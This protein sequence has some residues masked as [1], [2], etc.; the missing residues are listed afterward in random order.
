MKKLKLFLSLITLSLTVILVLASI[1]SASS[2]PFKDV[3]EKN[4]FYSYVEHVYTEGIMEGKSETIFDPN[5]N[6]TRAEFVT[7]IARLAEANTEGCRDSLE[8][9]TDA[10]KN[11]WYADAMGWGVKEGLVTGTSENTLAPNEAMTRAQLATFVAR[12]NDYLGITLPEDP[13][14]VRSFT[15]VKNGKWYSD[16]VEA[17][18]ESGLINGNGDGK[19]RPNDTSKRSETAAIISRFLNAVPEDTENDRLEEIAVIHINTETGTDVTSKEDY[20]RASFTLKDKE[21]RDIEVSSMRIRGRG[22]ATWNMEK[23]S[24]RLKFDEKI[25]LMSN[26]SG[27]TTENKDWTLLANHCDKSHLRNIIAMTLGKNLE[28][29]DWSPYTELV[30][31]YLNGEYRGIYMLS[32]QV[33]VGDQRVEIEDGEKDDIGFLIEL[34]NYAAGEFLSD[35][36][37]VGDKRYSVKS[38]F[39]NSDQVTA[40]QLHMEALLNIAKE[41]D[42]A[43]IEEYFD[44]D[45]I[46]DM[47]ILQEFVRNG[48]VGYS[49]FFMYVDSPHGKL[50]FIAP[51][52]FDLAMG[53]SIHTDSPE[54]L[55]AAHKT[56][57]NGADLGLENPWFAALIEHKWFREMIRD[58][59]AEKK[60]DML[61][62]V[63]ECC[64]YGYDN[65]EALDRNFDKWKVLNKQINQEPD[66]ILRLRSAKQNIDY[67][68]NWLHTRSAWLEKTFN[69]ALFLKVY[70]YGDDPVIGSTE[71]IDADVWTI[72][73]W[74]EGY[75]ECQLLVEQMTIHG[76][77]Q[78]ELGRAVTMSPESITRRVLVEQLGTELGKFA[79]IFDEDDYNAL[80]H[81]YQGVGFDQA[82]HHPCDFVVRNLETGEESERTQFTFH[83]T[84]RDKTV[85]WPN[86]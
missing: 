31:I 81:Q 24:Y 22:N 36:I 65:I 86:G 33:K 43:K 83:V 67:L 80:L 11:A 53:N 1:A 70:P 57:G 39:K 34:D 25:C 38:D 20:I 5:A 61:R 45:S 62:V 49:S 64:E 2:L 69:S 63:D 3:S 78:L 72:P 47:Y 77:V 16:S 14:A 26:P 10:K 79:I 13:E 21:G 60:D 48:D 40:L 12:L 23:K 58:R 66:A 27:G 35:Y 68:K 85:L 28:G 59:Y 42:Q 55:Q 37:R 17:L 7:I 56:D 32:E 74:F 44:L 82:A 8:A 73:D 54:G 15:D 46:L 51:W 29:I 18:R 75:N 52:D 76:I 71:V 6:V 84:K 50:H 30:E 19:F 9:F 4:W 41:G